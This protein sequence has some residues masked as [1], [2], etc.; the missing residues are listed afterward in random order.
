M[1]AKAGG[2]GR[3]ELCS[4][5]TDGGLTPSAALIDAACRSGIAKVNVLVR[6]RPGDFL[7]SSAEI[8]LMESDIR[9]AIHAGATGIVVGALTPDGDVDTEVCARL[10]DAARGA[11]SGDVRITFHRAFDVAR[12]AS[13]ALEK[14]I[15]LGCDCLLTSGM[16]ASAVDGVGLIKDLVRQSA[17]RIVIMAGAGVNTANAAS[18]LAATGVGAIHST[19]RRSVGSAMRFRRPGVPMG[20]PG[21]DEYA[22]RVTSPDVVRELVKI[23]D[24]FNR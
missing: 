5:L 8:H 14:V 20:A 3:I 12:D 19:A 7:Y 23:V 16:A 24:S 4:G 13:D 15:A 11:S 10:I 2:A 9:Q 6:P 22:P 21:Q 18:I 1:A 17:G